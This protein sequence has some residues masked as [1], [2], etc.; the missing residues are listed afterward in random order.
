MEA[1]LSSVASGRGT[2]S[3][4]YGLPSMLNHSCD[5]SVDAAWTDGDATLVLTARRDVAAG[6]ELR[7]S[8]IDA[9][10]SASAR[11]ETL[12][13][14]YGFECGCERCVEEAGDDANANANANASESESSRDSTS[15]AS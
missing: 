2:G 11:R 7:I 8:Y 13:H 6:E 10:A 14:A 9:D 5:P 4:L 12:R 15:L 1:A 3:A